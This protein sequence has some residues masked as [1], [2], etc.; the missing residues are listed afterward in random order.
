MATDENDPW[1]RAMRLLRKI[2]LPDLPP[3]VGGP[4]AEFRVSQTVGIGDTLTFFANHDEIGVIVD[5]HD[6]TKIPDVAHHE[7]QRDCD[8]LNALLFYA[9]RRGFESGKNYAEERK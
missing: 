8:R 4:N 7:A 6:G 3:G 2:N 9:W 1:L 5:G